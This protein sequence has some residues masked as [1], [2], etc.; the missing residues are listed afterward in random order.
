MWKSDDGSGGRSGRLGSNDWEGGKFGRGL[1][2]AAVEAEGRRVNFCAVLAECC[3]F[4]ALGFKS[5][6]VL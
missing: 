4:E 5:I 2:R 1:W 6:L 3:L